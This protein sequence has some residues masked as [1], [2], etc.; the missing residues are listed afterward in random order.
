M[1]VL[2][3]GA[4]PRA[5]ETGKGYFFAKCQRTLSHTLPLRTPS[6]SKNCFFFLA[7]HVFVPLAPDAQSC[8]LEIQLQVQGLSQVAIAIGQEGH[9]LARLHSQWYQRIRNEAKTR[10]AGSFDTKGLL[11]SYS[12]Y[13]ISYK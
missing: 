12:V 3:Q 8:L 5:G 13:I 11:S 10:R 1:S 7:T 6:L 2:R 4:A 9:G